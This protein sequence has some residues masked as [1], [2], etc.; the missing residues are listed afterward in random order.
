MQTCP[1]Y[2]GH[3][4]EQSKSGTDEASSGTEGESKGSGSRCGQSRA[5]QIDGV[6]SLTQ[7]LRGEVKPKLGGRG[8]EVGLC[9]SE[10]YNTDGEQET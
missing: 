4:N 9:L 2:K 1:P 6:S 3:R 7:L 5:R 8:Q 10:V